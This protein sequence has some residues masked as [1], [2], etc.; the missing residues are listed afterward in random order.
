MAAFGLLRA[1]EAFL[2]RG[3]EEAHQA[4][5]RELKAAYE[6]RTGAF[7]PEDSWFDARSAAF[8][9]DAIAGGF[10][11][12]VQDETPEQA[13]AYT[14]ALERAHR[15]L[16]R[17]QNTHGRFVLVCAISLVE[18]EIDP[19]SAGLADALARAAGYVDGRVAGAMLDG[20]REIVL[21]PGAVFHP[22]FATAAIDALLPIAAKKQLSRAATLDALLRMDRALQAMSRGKP[23]LAYRPEA[24]TIARG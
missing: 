17:V 6:R 11:G 2:A 10:A 20:A 1:F 18:L 9:D 13:R 19:P 23:A 24:L 21:L 3:A 4:R 7:T 8:W 22:A 14:R 12:A 15:G 16:Y 5:V